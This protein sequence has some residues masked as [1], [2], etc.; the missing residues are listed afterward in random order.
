MFTD[1]ATE[2]RNEYIY[3][4]GRWEKGIEEL[5]SIEKLEWL[6]NCVMPVLEADLN[7]KGRDSETVKHILEKGK[8]ME[9]E[10]AR[11]RCDTL[12]HIKNAME[13]R[14][15]N[16]KEY[17]SHCIA[18]DNFPAVFKM[19]SCGINE[20]SFPLSE[21]LS[22]EDGFDGNCVD[23]KSTKSFMAECTSFLKTYGC[24]I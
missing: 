8:A 5:R 4:T 7:K 13:E 10:L 2:A 16:M 14:R 12:C 15:E 22:K 6:F 11:R 24:L 18:N 19:L 21:L 23:Y 20:F 1:N 17:I 9:E 3:Y